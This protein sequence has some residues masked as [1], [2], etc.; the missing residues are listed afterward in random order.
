MGAPTALAAV[1]V[2]ARRRGLP[3][4]RG[5][6]PKPAKRRGRRPN[7]P[8][9]PA[10]LH[11]KTALIRH[12]KR[13][14]NHA[15]IGAGDDLG[16]RHEMTGGAFTLLLAKSGICRARPWLMPEGEPGP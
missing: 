14:E 10:I 4:H 16:G 3:Q 2:S 5:Q 12:V 1:T 7:R 11:A 8:G 6:T 9:F 13:C 15:P